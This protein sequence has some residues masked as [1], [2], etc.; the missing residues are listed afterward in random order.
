L[1]KGVDEG[2]IAALFVGQAEDRCQDTG[3]P[4]RG[5]VFTVA[6]VNQEG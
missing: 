6:I 5:R 4:R 3:E 2:S 1:P